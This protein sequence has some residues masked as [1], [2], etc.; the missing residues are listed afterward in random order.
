MKLDYKQDDTIKSFYGNFYRGKYYKISLGDFLCRIYDS[1]N[2]DHAKKEVDRNFKE[3]EEYG[4]T[5]LFDN[6]FKR[7]YIKLEK[8]Y[9]FWQRDVT[10][11][12][13]SFHHHFIAGF[14]LV[15]KPDIRY[16]VNDKHV[17]IVMESFLNFI[18]W[19]MFEKPKF[20]KMVRKMTYKKPFLGIFYI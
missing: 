16:L 12:F 14:G 18:L 9:K 11:F 6:Y 15:F 13:Y 4:I 3:M 20:Y 5:D 17:F 1:T 10:D 7:D 2:E 8:Y 19:K